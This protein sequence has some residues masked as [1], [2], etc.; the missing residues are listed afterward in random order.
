MKRLLVFF[1]LAFAYVSFIWIPV[2]SK[3]EATPSKSAFKEVYT[4]TIVSMGGR[5]VSTGFSLY[6]KEFTSDEDFN[7]YL[8]ILSEGD[9][10]DVLKVI[11][12]VDLGSFAPTGQVG[13]RINVAR[14]TV[15]PDGRT[16]IVV[17][18]ERWLKYAEVRNGYRTED[19]PFG[20]MEIFIDA[21][22]KGSGTYIAACAVDLKHDK[23]T[24][25]DRLEL[26]N[27]GTYPHRVMGVMR[28]N[29][30]E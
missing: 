5:M 20:I 6:I 29:K 18:F 19:Y 11:R 23:K 1:V 26:E 3:A 25:Q 17:A 4:G 28:R 27:F 22:G 16:R 8:S 14:K 7:R 13:R 12:D 9:Q 24:G 21:K 15:L 2:R 30:K 10:L